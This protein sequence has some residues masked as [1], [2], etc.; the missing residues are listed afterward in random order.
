MNLNRDNSRY[1]WFAN[2]ATT[3]AAATQNSKSVAVRN[4]V[5]HHPTTN[6]RKVK[7][8]STPIVFLQ[9]IQLNSI[10]LQKEQADK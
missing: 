1:F 6:Q 10:L 2:K 8:N 7:L 9:L 3:F 5:Q 4:G